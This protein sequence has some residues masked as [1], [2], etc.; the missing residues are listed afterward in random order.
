MKYLITRKPGKVGFVVYDQDTNRE[1][2]ITCRRI[3][4]VQ[5]NGYQY[6]ID[7]YG[8]GRDRSSRDGDRPRVPRQL[9]AVRPAVVRHAG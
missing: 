5:V 9:Q 3:T 4:D 1:A 6:C 2:P 8:S 7:T